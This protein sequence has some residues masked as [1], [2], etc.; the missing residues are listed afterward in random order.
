MK[1]RSLVGHNEEGTI[2]RL[3]I[4]RTELGPSIARH[5]GR[6]V[7]TMGDGFLIE[8]SSAVD[9][10]RSAV[11]LQRQ[12]AER[13][14]D[15]PGDTRMAFRIGVNLGDI[16]VQGDDILGDGVNIAARLEGIAVPGGVCIAD[17]VGAEV[18]G[19]IGVVFQDGGECKV[20]NIAQPVR[21]MH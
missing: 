1:T 18:A 2:T 11:E 12:L 4:L 9:A 20:K 10:V 15:L 16:I 7:K 5:N 21:A 14:N 8:H 19:K 13:N 6:M 17:K 3:N